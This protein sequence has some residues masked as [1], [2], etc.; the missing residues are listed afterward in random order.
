VPSAIDL[1][2]A[3]IVSAFLALHPHVTIEVIAETSLIDIVAQGFDAGVRYEEAIALD[4][5]AVPLGSAQRHVVVAAPQLLKA[6]GTPRTPQE[7]LLLPCLSVRFPSGLQSPWEFEKGRRKVK[8]SPRGPL[9]ASHPPLLM[10]AAIDGL[11]FLMIPE[12]Y[13]NQAVDHGS[14][15]LVLEEWSVRFPAPF[16]YYPSRRQPPGTLTTFIAFVKEWRKS[17]G[18]QSR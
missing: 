3:P 1:A 9:V 14:L 5:I 2:L 16:L 8:I 15:S 13:T 7:L 10:R 12:G 11:G 17:R 18:T 6:V 4:M